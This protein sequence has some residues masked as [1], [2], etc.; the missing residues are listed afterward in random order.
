VLTISIEDINF[1]SWRVW[2]SASKNKDMQHDIKFKAKSGNA[3][4]VTVLGKKAHI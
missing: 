1:S 2:N 3:S 4:S